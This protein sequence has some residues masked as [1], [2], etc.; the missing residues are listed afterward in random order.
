MTSVV[1][2]TL[3]VSQTLVDVLTTSTTTMASVVC[4]CHLLAYRCPNYYSS[5]LI[6]NII[7]GWVVL[8]W[9]KI[10]WIGSRLMCPE[11]TGR[12]LGCI[13]WHP[14]TRGVNLDVKK[15]TRV[16]GPSTWPV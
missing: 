1:T 3:F 4:H 8:Y 2:T 10:I 6:R 9:I 11:L 7:I 5:D 14:S 16:H 15:C 12:Q 13:F